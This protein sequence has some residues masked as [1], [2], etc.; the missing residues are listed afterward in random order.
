MVSGFSRLAQQLWQLGDIG[1][2]APGLVA[3]EQLGR[4]S[5]TRLLLEIHVGERLPVGV[6]D[7]ETGVRLFGDPRRREAAGF[8]LVAHRTIADPRLQA[9]QAQAAAVLGATQT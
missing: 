6:A 7:D 8:G 5:T 9:A 1:G 3:G 4:R 2:D